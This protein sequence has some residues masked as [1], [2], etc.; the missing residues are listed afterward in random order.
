[1]GSTVVRSEGKIWV[2][3]RKNEEE[4]DEKLCMTVRKKKKE[5]KKEGMT[6]YVWGGCKRQGVNQGSVVRDQ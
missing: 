1:M 6:F 5:E 3:L 2:R 4:K